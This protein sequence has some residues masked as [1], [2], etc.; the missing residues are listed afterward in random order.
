MEKNFNE[1]L[2][3]ATIGGSLIL[4]MSNFT[5]PTVSTLGLGLGGV[6][7]GSLYGV[8]RILSRDRR[9]LKERRKEFCEFFKGLGL[10]NKNDEIPQLANIWETEN[11]HMYSFINPIG[12]SSKSYEDRDIAIR[13]YLNCNKVLF[14]SN[15][16]FMNIQTI[17]T[18]LPT[19]VPFVLPKRKSDDLIIELGVN[20][21]GKKVEINFSKTHSWLLARSNWFW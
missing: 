19:I 20:E 10:H 15:G 16:D 21:L 3:Y 11:G 17:E 2:T 18:E 6:A 5:L 9:E 7:V 1:Q 8:Y 4:G 12:L 14:E 13:E